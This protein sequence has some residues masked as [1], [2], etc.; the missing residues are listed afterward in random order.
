M[1]Q[2]NLRK[3]NKVVFLLFVLLWMTLIFIFSSQ[4][5]DSQDMKPWLK[6]VLSFEQIPRYLYHIQLNYGGH[7]ISIQSLGL[8]GFV[9][10]FIR[11]S[12]HVTEYAVLGILI[13][14][15]LRVIFPRIWGIS[16][17]SISL[18][19]LYAVT[20]EY[21]QS[22]IVDRTPL[23]ADVLLDTGGATAGILLFMFIS[24]VISILYQKI[25]RKVSVERG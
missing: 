7:T 3:K 4:P 12:A 14:Q 16:L 21:H 9:E 13:F 17:I 23:F 5:Y 18:C 11:K 10:F 19:Y 22:F 2:Q 20:D 8:L 6:S 1:H 24:K 25:F 15:T